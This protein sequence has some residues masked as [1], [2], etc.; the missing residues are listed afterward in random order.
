MSKEVRP[1]LQIPKTRYD[2][3]LEYGAIALLT[4]LWALTFWL[5]QNSPDIIPTHYGPSGQPDDWGSKNTLW[6]VAILATLLFAG[7]FWLSGH[8]HLYNYLK[9]ITEHNAARE[10]VRGARLVRMLG[11]FT[12][13]VFCLLQCLTLTHLWKIDLNF[14]VLLL[15]V[16]LPLIPLIWYFN[17]A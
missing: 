5:Y 16:A 4:G 15:I 10:Y 2:Q 11:L 7:Q 6:L 1:V 9:P 12:T 17:K 3:V 13:L 14:S 8:P